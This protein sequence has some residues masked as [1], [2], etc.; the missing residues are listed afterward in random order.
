AVF[1]A[2]LGRIR[3]VDHDIAQRDVTLRSDAFDV[4]AQAK[5]D[6]RGDAFVDDHARGANDLRLSTFGEYDPLRIANCPVDYSAH[7]STRAAEP[8]LELFA[9]T[10]EVDHL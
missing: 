7:D 1:A 4:C 3:I 8:R 5:E 6:R 2:L 10:L 9:I